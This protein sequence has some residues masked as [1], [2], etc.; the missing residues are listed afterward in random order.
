MRFNV[1]ITETL[2]SIQSFD[3]SRDALRY[4]REVDAW[5]GVKLYIL[6]NETGIAY[7]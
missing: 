2:D 6:D 3:T 4:V 7:K 1:I 5:T